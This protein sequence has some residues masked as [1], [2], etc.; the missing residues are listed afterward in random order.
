[1]RGPAAGRGEA[2]PAGSGGLPGCGLR[3]AGAEEGGARP[4]REPLRGGGPLGGPPRV[5]GWAPARSGLTMEGARGR[6]PEGRG[7]GAA[8]RGRA[9]PRKVRPGTRAAGATPGAAAR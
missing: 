9:A 4:P 8:G 1:M 7:P 5:R 6:G 2:G 3:G